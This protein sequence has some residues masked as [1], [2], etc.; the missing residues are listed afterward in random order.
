MNLAEIES[1][2]YDIL[3]R[4]KG[5][6]NTYREEEEYIHWALGDKMMP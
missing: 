6:I 4:P 2:F 3:V 5:G 1:K